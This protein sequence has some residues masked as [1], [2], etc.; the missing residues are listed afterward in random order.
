MYHCTNNSQSK[1][2]SLIHLVKALKRIIRRKKKS[3]I[4]TTKANI[5]QPQHRLSATDTCGD[6][7]SIYKVGGS[8]TCGLPASL[9]RKQMKKQIQIG[10]S[11]IQGAKFYT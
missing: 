9:R 10:C 7:A 6:K 5:Y 1:H 4:S 2:V 3:L 8:T 11:K